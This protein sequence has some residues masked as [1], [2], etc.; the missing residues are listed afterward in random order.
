LCMEE[1]EEISRGIA[2]GLS[3]RVIATRLGRNQS[4][5]WREIAHN[6]GRLDYRAYQAAERA[7]Q[8]ACRPKRPLHRLAGGQVARWP[9][10]GGAQASGR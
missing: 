4:V 8:A 6:G 7:E 5:V 10:D 1:R 2:E 3:D 9:Q